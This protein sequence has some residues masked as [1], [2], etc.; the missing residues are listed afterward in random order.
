M[1]EVYLI[2]HAKSSWADPNQKDHDRPLN[3]RGKRDAPDMAARLA[4]TG[5][6]VDGILT[7]SAKRTRQTAKV[8]A[9]AFGLGKSRIVKEKKLYHAGPKTIQKCIQ[10]LPEDWSTVLVF[11]H[12]PGY[13]EAANALQN[14]DYIGNVPTCGIIGSRLETKKWSKWTLA[15]A[16]RTAFYYPKQKK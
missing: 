8:F 16:T 3:S 10:D 6:K 14:D 15:D 11:G 7:S 1:K 9:E 13:T 4:K 5:L 2:R 12:N